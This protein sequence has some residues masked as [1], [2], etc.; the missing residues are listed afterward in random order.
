MYLDEVHPPLMLRRWRPL[1][2]FRTALVHIFTLLH[3]CRTIASSWAHRLSWR[4]GNCAAAT[5]AAV[6]KRAR[7]GFH[8]VW[9]A[10]D[11]AL[12]SVY[13]L[14]V[15]GWSQYQVVKKPLHDVALH[16]VIHLSTQII[17]CS[18]I[19]CWLWVSSFFLDRI[20]ASEF[21]SP[22][23]TCLSEFLLPMRVVWIFSPVSILTFVSVFGSPPEPGWHPESPLVQCAVCQWSWLCPWLRFRCVC[24]CDLCEVVDTFLCVLVLKSGSVY[25]PR[26][27]CN[28]EIVPNF[29]PLCNALDLLLGM[30]VLIAPFW[31][32]CKRDPP[33]FFVRSGTNFVFRWMVV[34]S[35]ELEACDEICGSTG[36][37]L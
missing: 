35:S 3:T 12:V 28:Y 1:P 34:V 6:G 19:N 25:A 32:D 20:C 9:R 27:S 11:E 23:S 14:L 4:G 5:T 18:I 10:A 31:I 8:P 16:C 24:R 22:C 29:T 26:R 33:F 37:R 30:L 36:L 7:S 13:P 15:R 21:A 2:Q 17:R